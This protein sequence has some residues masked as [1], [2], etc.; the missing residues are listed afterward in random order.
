[1]RSPKAGIGP[2]KFFPSCG[3][4]LHPA[5]AH[6]PPG[7][8]PRALL[9]SNQNAGRAIV[10]QTIVQQVQ[11]LAHKTRVLVV[12]NADR[13]LHDGIRI[14][15]SVFPKRHRHRGQLLTGC[16][17]AIKILPGD[18]SRPSPRRGHTEHRVFAVSPAGLS[19]ALG[20]SGPAHHGLAET[21]KTDRR[22]TGHHIGQSG[23]DHHRRPLNTAGR[24]PS[25]RPGLIIRAQL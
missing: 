23:A 7:H 14:H 25:V 22:H 2:D 13:C 4:A 12:F 24:K 16:A 8:V 3:Q 5:D 21:G 19:P 20:V 9:S 17:K 11:R 6:R 15:G 18:Q 1:M 10:N